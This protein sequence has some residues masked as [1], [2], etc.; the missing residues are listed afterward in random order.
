MTIITNTVN[1]PLT[2]LNIIDLLCP[3]TMTEFMVFL[4]CDFL[5]IILKTTERSCL[6]NVWF[7]LIGFKKVNQHDGYDNDD[8]N[9]DGRLKLDLN[10]A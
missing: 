5:F 6:I 9:D 4:S 8:Q 1:Y 7:S 2:M 10:T 3:S